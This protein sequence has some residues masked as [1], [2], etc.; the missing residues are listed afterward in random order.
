MKL[1]A[2]KTVGKTAGQIAIRGGLKLR[3]ASP[4]IMLAGGIV[5]GVAAVVTACIATKK[6]VEEKPVEAAHDELDAIQNEADEKVKELGESGLNE[7]ILKDIRKEKKSRSFK[8]YCKLVKRL[9]RIFG[10][11]AGLLLLSIGLILGSHGILKK[12]YV[13]TTLAYKAMDEAFK[14]YRKR[15]Q[16]GVG[17]EKELHFFN[18]T[19]EGGETTIIDENGESKTEKKNVQVHQ[20]RYSPYEFDFN[21]ST[22]PGN[23]E[24]NTD[25]N[26]CFLRGIQNYLNDLLHS[27]GH[28]FLNEALDALGLERTREGAV[29]GWLMHSGGDDYVDLGISEYFTDLYSDIQDGYFKNIH[30]N[31]NVDGVIWNKI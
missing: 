26:L 28:L 19:E 17:E 16:E 3:K 8:A 31:F 14:D 22:A 5:A 23:W 10:P 25:Y 2:I 11:S 6:Y 9:V 1:D 29:V 20:K 7:E 24:A 18:G 27:R 30:L 15:V 21:A 12:R 13:S 4:E